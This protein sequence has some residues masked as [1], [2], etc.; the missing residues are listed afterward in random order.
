M[1]SVG[2][3]SFELQIKGLRKSVDKI[4]G[5]MTGKA[6]M[7]GIAEEG[8]TI[9]QRRT[10]A[11]S[12]VKGG[13]FK[14]YTDQY[15]RFRQKKG[16]SAKVDL[17]FT[18]RMMGAMQSRFIKPGLAVV[19]FSRAEEAAKAGGI[20]KGGRNFF[21]ITRPKEIDAI[22]KEGGRLIDKAMKKAGLI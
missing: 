1:I 20:E 5:T 17:T 8:L 2:G 18:G 3:T 12:N 7:T 16:R 19:Q 15:R 9:V 11:G 21:G 10:Q 4:R 14:K 22:V 6:V 13:R